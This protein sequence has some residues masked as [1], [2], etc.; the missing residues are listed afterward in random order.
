MLQP[1]FSSQ[2]TFPLK[3]RVPPTN[4][5][6]PNPSP[7]A[8]PA[9]HSPAEPPRSFCYGHRTPPNPQRR[10]G[11]RLKPP[12]DHPARPWRPL[13]PLSLHTESQARIQPRLQRAPPPTPAAAAAILKQAP[14]PAYPHRPPASRLP[15]AVCAKSTRRITGYA[16][17]RSPLSAGCRHGPTGAPPGRTIIPSVP[18]GY[19][20]VGR[21][22]RHCS[23]L[24]WAEIGGSRGGWRRN[25]PPVSSPTWTSSPWASQGY[26]VSGLELQPHGAGAGRGRGEPPGCHGPSCESRI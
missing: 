16:G 21:T 17:N 13:P 23:L 12:I 14:L 11:S 5:H 18:C 9:P 15:L 7:Q 4:G 24:G 22:E 19:G 8:K 20:A 26:W 25:S 1:S 6:L 3:S 10:I 2:V